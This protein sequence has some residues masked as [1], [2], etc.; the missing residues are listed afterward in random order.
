MSDRVQL[1]R[2]LQQVLE[3]VK[4]QPGVETATL[5]ANLPGLTDGWQNDIWPEGQPQ[6]RPG[7]Q[8]N[9]DWSIVSADYF[10]TMK[11]PILKGRS[12]TKD[13]DEEGK[14]VLLVDENLARR[15]WPN[16]EAVGKHVKYDSPVWHEVIGVVREVPIFGSQAKPLIKIY[17]PMGRATQRN[18]VLSIRSSNADP[19]SLTAAIT[20]DSRACM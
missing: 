17:T 9:V 3:R 6:L 8:I 10:T 1:R 13:E 16:E 11:I 5:S 12:F 15:F 18:P 20:R 19:Q 2:V 14:P 7:E 4:A